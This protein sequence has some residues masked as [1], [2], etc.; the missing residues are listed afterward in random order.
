MEENPRKLPDLITATV[1]FSQRNW[2]LEIDEQSKEYW[3]WRDTILYTEEHLLEALCFDFD[4]THPYDYVVQLVR[5]LTPG[6]SALGRC[7]WAF[8]NDRSRCGEFKLTRSHRTMMQI[9]YPPHVIA[10]AAF[11]FARKFTHTDVPRGSDGK[12]WWEHY[13]VRIEQLRGISI[14]LLFLMKT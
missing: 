4:I 13:G 12:E 11:Y 7:A 1:R 10:A 9:M 14:V 2:Q 5:Q 6:N 8:V 3:K